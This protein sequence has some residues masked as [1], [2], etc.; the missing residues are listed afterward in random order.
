MTT[1]ARS[2]TRVRSNGSQPTRRPSSSVRVRMP[3][4]AEDREAL[5]LGPA[6]Q[7]LVTVGPPVTIATAL[8]FYFGWVR[9]AKQSEALGLDESVFLMSTR[10]YVLRSLDSLYLPIMIAAIAL[11][12]WVIVHQRLVDM[13]GVGRH[14]SAVRLVA[15]AMAL[16]AWW[17]VPLLGLVLRSVAPEWGD[18]F[19]PVMV[20]VGLLLSEYGVRLG[21]VARAALGTPSTPGQR[22]TATLRSVLVGVLVVV[23]LFWQV[24]NFA[25][26]VG[27]GHAAEVA[28]TA[29]G[30]PSVVIYSARNLQLATPGV[31]AEQVGAEDAAYR[32]RYSG[33]HLLQ[34]TGGRF[35]LLPNGWTPGS[36][37]L[38]VLRDDQALRFEFQGPPR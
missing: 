5:A 20:T 33:L 14:V 15:H 21:A 34:A 3:V 22:W 37:P 12:A 6:L 8:L 2:T 13:M 27:R 19:L 25:E 30:F 36:A 28:A 26:V 35:F 11:L 17:A 23:T 4:D 9:S 10:D 16:T 32:F 1:T 18:L 7:T 24:A 31:S 29:G 38:I